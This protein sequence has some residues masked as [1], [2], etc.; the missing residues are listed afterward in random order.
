NAG[1]DTIFIDNYITVNDVPTA[2][3]ASANNGLNVDFTNNSSDAN[4]YQW[5]FGDGQFS[6]DENP[7]H[8]FAGAG[9]YSVQLIAINDCG[10]DTVS[11][12]VTILDQPIIAGFTADVTSGCAPLTVQFTDMSTNNPVAWAWSFTGGTP[13]TST[14]QNPTVVF[15]N[16]G[17]FGV[18]LIATNNAGSDTIFIDN[19][20]TVND[21]PTAAFASA[22]NGL[23]VDF[24]NNSSDAN[25]YQW[26]FG[27]GQFSTD[28]NPTHTFAGAGNYSVQLIAINDCGQDTV[29]QLVTIPNQMTLEAAFTSDNTS[30]CAPFSVQFMDMTTNNPTSWSWT[31]EG[32][33]PNNSTEQNP[34]VTYPVSGHYKVRLIA[35]NGIQTDTLTFDDYITVHEKPMASFSASGNGLSVLLTNQS[36]LADS[37]YWDFGD[38]T[39]SIEENPTH[40]FATY[41]FHQ[42]TLIASN[43]CG[44]DT[45]FHDVYVGQGLPEATIQA[46]DTV[47]CG[48][49]TIAL[50]AIISN[51]DSVR[52][53][54]PQGDPF[55]STELEPVVTF[56]T[57]GEYFVTLTAYNATDS[58]TTSQR[59]QVDSPPDAHFTYSTFE[60]TAT[61]VHP[62][63]PNT[64][65][66]WDFGDG[67]ILDTI[68][69]TH[70]Y[71]FY[72]NY[73]V[74]LL[75]SNACGTDQYSQEISVKDTLSGVYYRI[76]PNPGSGLYLLDVETDKVTDVKLYFYSAW[77]Q[78]LKVYEWDQITRLR[79]E[80]L[81]LER[82]LSSAYFYYIEFGSASAA[83]RLLKID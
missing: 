74:L 41:G 16:P 44:H 7:T 60:K 56:N 49:L 37:Y 20:I 72:G 62:L 69:P 5:A 80:P 11:Q 8:T 76:N 17:Q 9:N 53:H 51:A 30:G 1:S 78:V 47:G 22:N 68:E 24:T 14:D 59:I 12:L 79:D 83:G 42:I 67:E 63:T 46:S 75:A 21:M 64:N 32:G 52:W 4:A 61:F 27:D 36:E 2:A 13:S 18:Q 6:T 43:G 65:Y 70:D 54:F 10:Q 3:F 38:S 55:T 33:E 71:D 58:V 19:Y 25:A 57:P 34:L 48:P 73:T 82:L 40:E 31:F 66:T 45:T 50:K 81:D 35:S 26:A 77:G 23:N 28:E 29:S 39:T 15:Q